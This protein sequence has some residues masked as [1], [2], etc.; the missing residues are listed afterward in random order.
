MEEKIELETKLHMI[1]KHEMK[2]LAELEAKFAEIS[3]NHVKT[4]A[5]NSK[6][7]KTC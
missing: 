4:R 5:E 1:K 6:L 3:A 7:K 2:K